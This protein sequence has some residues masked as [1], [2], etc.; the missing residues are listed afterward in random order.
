MRIINFGFIALLCCAGCHQEQKKQ[1]TSTKRNDTVQTT[2][3]LDTAGF[4]SGKSTY[5]YLKN[6]DTISLSITVDGEK[7]QGDLSYAWKEKDRNSGHI[8]GVLK[9]DILTADYTFSSEG[10][11]SVR[12]VI[13]KLS[14]ARA[15]EGY[16]AMEEKAGKMSFVDLKKIAFDEKFALE[17][18]TKGQ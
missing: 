9:G 15:M 1:V 11:E 6:G 5:Q 8:D 3:P 13:F 12:Q 16:G 14:K 18:V 10:Q 17:N 4:F 7:V 2:Q